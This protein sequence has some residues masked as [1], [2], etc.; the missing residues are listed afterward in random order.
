MEADAVRE[1]VDEADRT[2]PDVV[3]MNV[4]LA[5]GSGIEATRKIRANHRQPAVLMH[6]S[7]ADDEA[8]SASIMAGRPATSSSRFVLA[9]SSDR[10][11][12]SEP[13]RACSTPPSR[14]RSSIGSAKASTS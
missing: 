14:R 8:L 5:D 4:R 13:A 3:V 10:S 2:R 1:A 9:T 6:T 11:A 7:F 12:P